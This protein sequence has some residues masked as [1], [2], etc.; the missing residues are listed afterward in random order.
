MH[1]AVTGASAGIGEAIAREFARAGASVTLVARRRSELDRIAS[2]L[3]GKSFV[4]A[5]DLTDS[6]HA[7]DWIPA[8]EAALG[9]IDVLVS[10]AGFLTLGAVCTLDPEEGE[11]MLKINLL[12]PARLMRAV[13]P[14]MLARRSGVIVNV[15]SLA[16]LV[17]L[18]DWVYQAAG[19]AGSA[20][21]S[22]ALR[23]ELR[24]TGVHAMTMYPGM[25]DTAM[26][27]SGLEAYGKKGLT[28]LIPLGNTAALARGLRRA[29]ERRRARFIYPRMYT[30]AWW[31]PK[32]VGWFSARLAP[33]LRPPS[34]PS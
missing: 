24:G 32:L 19:K 14:G 20:A 30:F 23:V 27:Q 22:E 9:P 15:T 25:T 12:T 31:F 1:V 8:A 28:R 4:V 13:L 3:E 18:P 34:L 10:N 5:Q 6:A 7:A 29:V 33:R 2:E 16:A 11:R 17:P 26:T 21:F